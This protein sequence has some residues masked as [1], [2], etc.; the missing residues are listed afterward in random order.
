[1][2][3]F[4]PQGIAPQRR[5]VQDY[6]DS[7]IPDGHYKEGTR[8][9]QCGAIYHNQRWSLDPTLVS[10]VSQEHD[11]PMVVCPGCRKVEVKDP[12]GVVTLTGGFWQEHRDE[13]LNL[14]QNEEKRAMGVNPLERLIE[15]TPDGE[16]LVVLT[17]NEKLAQRLGRALRKA[18]NGT[19][20][21][22]WSE[23][24]KLARVIWN[25]DR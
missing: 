4:H 6:H 16:E 10:R 2:P 22:R 23:D 12:G 18:Y 20:E 24:N 7:Y 1:M 15:I 19:V 3:N 13:I 21:Y 11:G 14:I 9:S 25:R 5:S 8:C 17:T